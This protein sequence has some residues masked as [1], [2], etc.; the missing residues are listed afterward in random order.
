[1]AAAL[2]EILTVL[3]SNQSLDQILNYIVAQAGRLL[4]ADAVAIYRLHPT[5]PC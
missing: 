4:R 2:R 1:L 5:R 3:N